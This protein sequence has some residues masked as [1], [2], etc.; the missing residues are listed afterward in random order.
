M[1][2]SN[3]IAIARCRPDLNGTTVSFDDFGNIASFRVGASRGTRL[4]YKT[5]NLYSL[6]LL[7]WQQ[8]IQRLNQRIVAGLVHDYYEVVFA[9]MASE[10]LLP[11]QAVNFD[12]GRWCE[13]DTTE[14]IIIAERLF[15]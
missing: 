2:T 9:E 13:I 11:W 4:A 1:R 5:V 8:V 15:A 3:R 7:V 6:S 14:D 10:G 12:D